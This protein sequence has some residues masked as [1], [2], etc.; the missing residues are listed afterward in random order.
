VNRAKNEEAGALAKAAAR[1]EALPSDVFYH[2]IGTLAVRSPEGLQIT[3]DTEG[4]HIVNLIMTED[5]RAP[6]T[7]FLQRYYHPSDISEAKLL[8]HRSQDF[9]L[10]EG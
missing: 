3:N 1:G 8:K 4:H 2:V 7:M 5:W 6:I 10:I 9:A